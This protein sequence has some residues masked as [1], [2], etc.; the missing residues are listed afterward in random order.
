VA[1]TLEDRLG[2][3]PNAMCMLLCRIAEP[4]EVVPL[5]SG[6]SAPRDRIRP[7]G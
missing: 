1:R 3:S 7:V 2:L 4:A 6:S 5:V